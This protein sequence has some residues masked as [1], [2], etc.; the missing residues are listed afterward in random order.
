V[1]S[2]KGGV[3]KST[4]AAQLALTLVNEG[5]RVGLL[6]ID[7]TGPSIPQILGLQN[8]AVHSSSEG[9]VPV[10]PSGTK[11]LFSVMSIGFLL[12]TKES[13]V[14]WRG[15]KKTAMIRSFLESV[16]W[17][18]L[19]YLVIDTPPGTSDEHI[20]ICEL[21]KELNPDGAL[22]VTTPQA[23]SLLDV[24]KEINFCKKIGFPILGVLENMSGFICPHCSE[25]TNVFSTGGGEALAK[26]MNVP[27]LGRLPLDP[28]LTVACDQGKGFLE[29]HS[30]S[31]SLKA[32]K[33]F[34]QQLIQKD[35]NSHGSD[36]KQLN[37]QNQ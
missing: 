3:G 1:L 37:E 4:V 35:N 33:D 30:K 10:Y 27:F 24:S 7:L 22:I 18:T 31:Q 34:V 26:Q 21:L 15:P 5:K 11:Q 36:Q 2:G 29:W 16:C 8:H 32:L 12:D 20:T 23:V 6:D 14:I 28:Q 17:G 25:C 19:D 13:P 9:W